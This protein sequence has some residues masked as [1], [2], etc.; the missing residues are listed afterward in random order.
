MGRLSM[1]AESV[2]GQLFGADRS[3]DSISTD[4][5]A[6]SA[7][8][9]FFALR[10]E[11]FNAGEFID[12][13]ARL[14][15]AGA[16]VEQ[17]ADCEISQV[18]VDDARLALGRLA[19]SWRRKFD[20]PVIG[21]TGSNGK[22]TVRAMIAAILQADQADASAVLA[23]QGNLNNEIGLPLTVLRLRASHRCAVFE[24]G[25]SHAGEIAYLA[26]IA[27]PTVAIVT[28]AGP[29]HLEGFGSVA[30]VARAKGELYAAL[31]DDGIAVI[32]ADDDFRDTWLAL[33]GRRRVLT[34]GL[35]SSADYSAADI[36]RRDGGEGLEFTLVGP[37]LSLSI[38]LPMVGQHNL[39]NALGAAAASLAAGV[40]PQSVQ[41]GLATVQNVGGRLRRVTCASGATLYDDSY[42]ANPASVKAAMEFLAGQPGETWLLFGDMG[43][44]GADAEA[45]HAEVGHQARA[46]GIQ[47][48]LA[49]GPLSQAS[50]AAFGSGARHFQDADAL[51]AQ[52]VE[53]LHPGVVMLVKASRFMALDQL[54]ARLAESGEG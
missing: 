37:G 1:V 26:D 41:A 3:F 48:L 6:L 46:L 8:Q 29:A 9:L 15:A 40:K 32:N 53:Q 14:G 23:T 38:Q 30:G 4:T 10:G 39:L 19:R 35:Q 2:G 52:A 31:G 20:L 21:V 16:V 45:L 33:C 11:N 49:T 24:M 44:L 54:V 42:N 43:E 17:R 47:R 51:Y 28:N 5:R 12:Q 18:Q 27:A 7:G 22:T 34:F 25:A 13:A 50:V 36:T